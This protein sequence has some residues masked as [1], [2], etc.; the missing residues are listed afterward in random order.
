MSIQDFSPGTCEALLE[1]ALRVK[2]RNLQMLICWRLRDLKK[3]PVRQVT[4]RLLALQL[5]PRF[6]PEPSSH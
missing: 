3:V 4:P 1:Q 5:F 2:T 6:E